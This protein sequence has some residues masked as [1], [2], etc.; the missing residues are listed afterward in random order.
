[1]PLHYCSERGEVPTTQYDNVISQAP[2]EALLGRFSSSIYR[3][4]SSQDNAPQ[5]LSSYD[6]QCHER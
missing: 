1:M 6:Q 3:H 2:E 4:V 5:Q